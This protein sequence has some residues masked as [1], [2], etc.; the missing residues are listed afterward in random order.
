VPIPQL[1]YHV[2][3][4]GPADG[5]WR[6]SNDT[7]AAGADV[8]GYAGFLEGWQPQIRQAWTDNCIRKA[9]TCESHM[10]GDGRVIDRKGDV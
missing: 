6:L 8:V 3:Y 9:V 7:S 10:L 4:Q 2:L 1:E 5:A